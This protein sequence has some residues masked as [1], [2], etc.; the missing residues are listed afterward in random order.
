MGSMWGVNYLGTWKPGQ[1]ADAALF[2]AKP[3]DSRYEDLDGDHEITSNDFKIIGTSMPKFSVGWNNTF[4]YKRFSLNVFLQGL[5]GHDKLNYSYGVAVSATADS[6]QATHV[7]VLDHY[8][9]GTNETSD[10][11]AFSSTD[12]TFIQSSRFVQSGDFIR[13]KNISLSYT[14]HEAVL[15]GMSAKIF[16]TA[17]NLFTIT[18]YKGLDPESSSVSSATDVNLGIDYGSYPN[19]KSVTV[20]VNVNF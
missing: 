2:G 15:K 12:K 7:D 10:I 11:P 5:S 20:G 4:R 6:R 17:T 13:L 1:E 14:L 19:S 8:V 18:N 16:V 9:P 3:G